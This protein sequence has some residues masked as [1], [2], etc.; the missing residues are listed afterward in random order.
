MTNSAESVTLRLGGSVG[1]AEFVRRASLWSK[2]LDGL[3]AESGVPDMITWQISGLEYSSAVL[4]ATPVAGTPEAAEA[5][6]RIIH[7]YLG[8]ARSVRSGS[9][10]IDRPVLRL[11]QDLAATAT[12]NSEVT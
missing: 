2:I 6:P 11:V 4:T 8:A 5:V 3:T 12:P 7:E 9:T 1:V 10:G